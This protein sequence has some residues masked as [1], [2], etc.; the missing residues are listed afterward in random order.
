MTEHDDPHLFRF[1]LDRAIRDQLLTHL[2]SVPLL[3]LTRGVGPAESG[4]YALYH[5]D[6]LVYVGKVSKA[7]TKSGR[8]LRLRLNEHVRKISGRRKISLDD[9][10]VRYVTFESEWWLFAAEY[11]LIAYFRPA[12]NLSGFGGKPPGVGRP[13]T[14]RVSSW[15]EQF[16][17]Q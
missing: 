3:P 14:D 1:N 16:P 6:K 2:E 9:V 12:W 10:F 11:V 13:G 17:R 7:T 8:T 4:I 5:V 15:D